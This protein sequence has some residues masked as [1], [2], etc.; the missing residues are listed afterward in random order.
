MAAVVG[1]AI[2]AKAS[3]EASLAGKRAVVVGGTSGIGRGIALRMAVEGAD[4][5]VVGR[6]DRGILEEMRQHREG[7]TFKFVAADCFLLSN[8]A[9][10]ADELL[11]DETPLDFLVQSQGMAT[12]Q[13][14]TPSPEEGLDQK[15][16][17][18]VYSRLAFLQRLRPALE[19]ADD[20]RTLSVL[21]AGVHGAYRH[22]GD[23]PE[24]VTHYSIKN[25]ADA[26]G[27]YNDIFLDSLA[28]QNAKITYAHA[29]PGFVA[30]TWGNEMPTLIKWTVR[31]LQRLA[32]RPVETC[33][34]YMVRG[35]TNKDHTGFVLLDQ[36]GK[37][38]AKVTPNHDAAR[39]RVYERLVSVVNA[40][41]R[42]GM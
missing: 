39:E 15:L 7:G 11:S 26:A 30:S 13:G 10:A 27:F 3:G 22:H 28:R 5:T 37:R 24:L 19:K 1:A 4:V 42:P 25:A 20:P 23:D 21:S 16:C 32:G 14:F 38:T 31:G 33:A 35:L 29:A 8:V 12:I 41:K 34:E 40:G 2:V 9:K 6:S 18:H 36:Y 17:L